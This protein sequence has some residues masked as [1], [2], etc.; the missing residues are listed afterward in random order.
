MP[1]VAPIGT[2]CGPNAKPPSGLSNYA[3]GDGQSGLDLPQFRVIRRQAAQLIDA[4]GPG[5]GVTVLFFAHNPSPRLRWSITVGFELDPAQ[6]FTPFTVGTGPTWQMRAV[7]LPTSGGSP[8]DLND[9]FVDGAGT[10]TARS[11]P[12]G[13]E[14][15][16]AVK[17][18]R[19]TL[20]LFNGSG[21]NLDSGQFGNLVL[22]ARWEPHDGFVN[23]VEIAQLLAQAELYVV[24]NAPQLA[25]GT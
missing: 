5:T 19:G 17:D 22:E 13:Y 12:D 11:L 24:G 14:I 10:P 18:V 21:R 16:S 23:R 15:D 25:N 9:L 2:Y 3:G 7:R 20:N 1:R 4:A 8:A 6:T